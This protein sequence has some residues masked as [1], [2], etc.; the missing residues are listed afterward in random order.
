MKVEVEFGF[1][2]IVQNTDFGMVFLKSKTNDKII[3]ILLSI[4]EYIYIR[5]S[6][7][8]EKERLDLPPLPFLLMTRMIKELGG[9]VEKIEI[10]DLKN[11][12]YYCSIYIKKPDGKE[13]VFESNPSDAICLALENKKPIYVEENLLQDPNEASDELGLNEM[14]TIG[15]AWQILWTC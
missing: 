3:G 4:E 1:V 15:N 6:T 13:I 2:A 11:E 12:V 7:I 8:K 5:E 9:T 10:D 14:K